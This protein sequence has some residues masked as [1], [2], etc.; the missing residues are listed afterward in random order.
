MNTDILW[1]A[2]VVVIMVVVFGG[3]CQWQ[4][5]GKRE[6]DHPPKA[7]KAMPL[8]CVAETKHRNE[9]CYGIAAVRK[10]NLFGETA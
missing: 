7:R 3:A 2:V 5:K 9:T 10:F 6:G 4:G 8:R 1:A